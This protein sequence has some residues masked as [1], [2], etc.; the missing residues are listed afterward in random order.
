MDSQ[1][2]IR[3]YLLSNNSNELFNE[4]QSVEIQVK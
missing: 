4:A 3:I 1:Q 2:Q